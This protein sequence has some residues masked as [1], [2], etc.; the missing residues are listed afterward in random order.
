MYPTIA[1]EGSDSFDAISRSFSY[2]YARPWR[3]GFYSLVALF[4]GVLTYTFVQLFIFLI[5]ALTHYFCDIG[6]FVNAGGGVPLWTTMW[7]KPMFNQLIYNVRS[8]LLGSGANIGAF[9]LSVWVYLLISLLGAYAISFFLSA[10]TIIYYLMRHEV[11]ATEL[12]DVYV[13]QTDE[14]FVEAPPATPAPAPQAA[15]DEMSRE[16]AAAAP[17]PTPPP[18][19]EPPKPEDAAPEA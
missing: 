12:D 3:L 4:Y 8:D 5:L 15:P 6:V 14:D 16:E 9:C 11:D 18:A 19:E 17:V 1:V 10:N 2:L 7:P 13:E